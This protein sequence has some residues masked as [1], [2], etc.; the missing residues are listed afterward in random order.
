MLSQLCFITVSMVLMC[1]VIV[2]DCFTSCLDAKELCKQDL[3]CRTILMYMDISHMCGESVTECTI[4]DTTNCRAAHNTL[5]SMPTFQNCSCDG[6]A[7][8][9]EECDQIYKL[10]NNH[11]C[12]HRDTPTT[13]LVKYT[14]A[15]SQEI[16]DT[17]PSPRIKGTENPVILP[18]ANTYDC[19]TAR[20]ACQEQSQC[21]V[22]YTNFMSNCE[23]RKSGC[24]YSSREKCRQARGFL[25]STMLGNC[26]C[27]EG[28]VKE[29]KCWRLFRK[30]H[31]NPCLVEDAGKTVESATAIAAPLDERLADMLHVPTGGY[32]GGESTCIDAFTKC[33]YDETC[34]VYL[35]EYIKNCSPDH[36]SGACRKDECLT[37]IRAFF[38]TVQNHLT[39]SLVFCNCRDDDLTCIALREGLNPECSHEER[40][41]PYCSD[42]VTS[43][44]RDNRCRLSYQMFIEQCREDNASPTGCHGSYSACRSA[45]VGIMGTVIATSCDCDE[46]SDRLEQCPEFQIILDNQCVAKSARAF[47]WSEPLPTTHSLTAT[48][49]LPYQDCEVPLPLTDESL[50]VKSG[51]SVRI[52][53][54][55]E[56]CSRVC[57]CS[58]SGELVHCT[59]LPCVDHS[60]MCLFGRKK[61][62]HN[63]V[64]QDSKGGNCVCFAGDVICSVT[65]NTR[66][67]DNVHQE[68][69]CINIGY[70]Q[71][72][73]QFIQSYTN[74]NLTGEAVRTELEKLLRDKTQ[75]DDCTLDFQEESSG[76]FMGTLSKGISNQKVPECHSHLAM[77]SELINKRA[78]CIVT[79]VTLSVMKVATFREHSH[80]TASASA[81]LLRY[82][83]HSYHYI[84]LFILL[85]SLSKCLT[86]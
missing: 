10:L 20:A 2:S 72:E 59:E 63:D 37:S 36:I 48:L 32:N 54:N 31:Q 14:S 81:S 67:K 25:N 35:A 13:L 43:C 71:Q 82:S 76:V 3:G 68:R 41:M 50:T 52:P 78:L 30:L 49:P 51:G 34:R 47:F 7:A 86:K 75:S 84:F 27:F 23:S 70:S 77:L 39:H 38:D 44:N 55:D 26:Q 61:Y 9:F 29:R 74:V 8:T 46:T 83:S 69:S 85:Y 18:S 6:E 45:Y 12:I 4:T 79:D 1:Y 56:G 62:E 57:R 42:L 80:Q 5:I 65:L 19:N 33:N 11:P 40:P 15:K 66:T 58:S 21:S 60:A 73:E 17:A 64:F 16:S 53:L 24:V 28:M 22:L